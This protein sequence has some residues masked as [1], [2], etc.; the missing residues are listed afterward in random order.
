MDVKIEEV[1]ER[2]EEEDSVRMT[3]LTIKTEHEV[4]YTSVC[5]L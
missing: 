2:K 4:S 1:I 5:P 3:F